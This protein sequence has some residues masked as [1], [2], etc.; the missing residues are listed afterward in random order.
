MTQPKEPE[1]TPQRELLFRRV[2]RAR[3]KWG[4]KRILRR[5]IR[6]RVID[7]VEAFELLEEWQLLK[8]KARQL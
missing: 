7:L 1:L 4:L 3:T 8:E 2:S 5:A 6:A